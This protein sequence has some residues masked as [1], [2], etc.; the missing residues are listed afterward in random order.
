MGS[1]GG[2]RPWQWPLLLRLVRTETQ[3][4]AGQ[5]S[6]KQRYP[7]AGPPTGQWSKQQPSSDIPPFK[8]TPAIFRVPAM[9]ETDTAKNKLPAT[10]KVPASKVGLVPVVLHTGTR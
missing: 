7:V 6:Q 10:T 1:F 4:P 2:H 9:P 5:A 8:D 3:Y